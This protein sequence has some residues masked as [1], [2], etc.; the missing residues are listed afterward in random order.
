MFFVPV[1]FRAEFGEDVELV[2]DACGPVDVVEVAQ[3]AVAVFEVGF[4]Q[5]NGLAVAFAAFVVCGGEFVEEGFTVVV[6][7]QEVEGH[8]GVD[9]LPAA[10]AFGVEGACVDE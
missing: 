5:V 8:L 4:E 7:A 10:G 1:E 6:A 9:A 3:S 2:A